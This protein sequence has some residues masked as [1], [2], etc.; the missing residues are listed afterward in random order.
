MKMK[1]SS[2]QPPKIPQVVQLRMTDVEHQP[3]KEIPSLFHP[4]IT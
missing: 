1:I 3:I 2:K 4:G